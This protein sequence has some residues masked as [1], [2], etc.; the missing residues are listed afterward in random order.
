MP[1]QRLSSCYAILVL[2]YS[3]TGMLL[4]LPQYVPLGSEVSNLSDAT[5]VQLK[6]IKRVTFSNKQMGDTFLGSGFKKIWLALLILMAGPA[7]RIVKRP[8]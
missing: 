7:K 1:L 8:D 2:A 3:S 5:L 4:Y 6:K